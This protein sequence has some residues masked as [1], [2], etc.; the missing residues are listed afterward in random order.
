[1]SYLHPEKSP[2]L[3]C[4]RRYRDKNEDEC[5]LCDLRF[6][7]VL[8]ND[9]ENLCGVSR[10]SGGSGG[11]VTPN[12]LDPAAEL[13][14]IKRIKAMAHAFCKYHQVAIYRVLNTRKRDRQ[15]VKLRRSMLMQIR[16]KI[17]AA[18]NKLISK[19]LGLHPATV[20]LTLTTARE[21]GWMGG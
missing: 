15:V 18:K 4:P 6:G 21:E 14:V 19:A 9:P 7:Y 2:C 20:S 17:P 12:P 11:W 5:Q 16:V 1:M 10:Y 8:R 13:K 3:T